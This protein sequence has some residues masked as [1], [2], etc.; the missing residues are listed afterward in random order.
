[1]ETIGL[2]AGNGTFPLLFAAEARRRGYRVAAVAHRGETPEAIEAEV[3]TL[4]WVK[5]GQLGKMLRTFKKAGVA[6]AVMA[7]GINKV[8]S[9][10]SVRPDLRGVLFLRRA[11]GMGDDSLLR[12]LAAEFEGEGIQI[13]PST[14]FLERMLARTG[15]MAG[16][17]PSADALRDIELGRRVLSATG[18]LDVGQGVVVERGLVLAIEAIEG[19]DAAVTRA[20]A[21][22]RGGAVVVKMAKRGQ[23]MRFDVPA[24]GPET[25]ATMLAAGAKVLALEIGA[26]LIL[27]EEAVFRAATAAGISVV[28]VHAIEQ[29]AVPNQGEGHNVQ[30]V[31]DT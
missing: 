20:G 9:L 8:R 13:V 6:R 24:V 16:P 27:D 21:L 10:S 1:M 31:E 7:G 4:V 5:V 26:T 28:G 15:T 14:L 23:D 22:G 18:T 12:Q 3:D 2:I 19:T 25:I 29:D 17:E 11:V 30:H